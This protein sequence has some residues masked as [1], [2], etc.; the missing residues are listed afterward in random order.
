MTDIITPNGE[1]FI[2][3]L[4]EHIAEDIRHFVGDPTGRHVWIL[5][6]NKDQPTPDRKNPVVNYLPT[7]THWVGWPD[8]ELALTDVE[9]HQRYLD[10]FEG[11]LGEVDIAILR[12]FLESHARKYPHHYRQT[13][14]TESGS[15]FLITDTV[16]FIITRESLPTH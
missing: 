12:Q 11:A 9:I 10:I 6:K 1:P 7:P 13:N 3:R 15:L 5:R 8:P 14:N 4:K 2:T 16:T